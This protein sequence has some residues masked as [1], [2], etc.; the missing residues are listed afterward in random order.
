MRKLLLMLLAVTSTGYSLPFS[1]FLQNK[2]A[3]LIDQY[4]SFITDVLAV[5]NAYQNDSVMALRPLNEI[6]DWLHKEAPSISDTVLDNV[7][8][9][10]KCANEY[11]VEHNNLLTIIDYSMPSNE[12]RL[13]VFDLKSEKLL[14]NT[15]VSH[16]ITSGALLSDAFSNRNNSKSSSIG[17]YTTEKSYYGRDGLSLRLDGL[18]PG[19]ND[20]AQNRAVVMHGGWYV[21]EAFIKKYGRA[22]RSWGCPALPSNLSDSIINTIKDKSLFVIY[23]PS[24]S[25]FAKS[26]F[27]KCDKPS[28][29]HPA[30]QVATTVKTPAL[31]PRD[32][33]LFVDVNKNS[34]FNETKPVIAVTADYYE[35]AFH[36]KVPLTRMLRRQ[37]NNMEYIALTP[38]E[39]KT[40]ATHNSTDANGSQSNELNSVCF[41]TA[42]IKM[43]RGYYATEMKIVPYGK[44]KEVTLNTDSPDNSFTVHFEARPDLRLKTTN[45]FIRWVGL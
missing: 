39:L 43:R 37:I 27:L 8:T 40:L 32:E 16:G 7:L 5:V 4:K 21:E 14:F 38:T 12:K 25:W 1:Q 2:E 45:Q 30:T 20:N 22:G 15:Y 44:I 24:D 36:T 11:N 29:I 28:P 3:I 41:V 6:K 17:V 10:L 42:E 18:D 33:I 19:F 9:T 31:D 26:K 13:W 23:Y 35:Q 34:V